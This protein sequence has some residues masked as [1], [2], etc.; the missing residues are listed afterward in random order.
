MPPIVL[1]DLSDDVLTLRPPVAADVPAITRIC[2]DPDIQRWTRVP[3]PYGPE[4]ART[5]VLM[6][7]GA[8]AE[9]RGAHLLATP[10]GGP[11]EEVWGCV[12]VSR[13]AADLTGELGYWVAPG[14]RGQRVATRA[15]RLMARFAFDHLGLFA[16]HLHT[17]TG[18]AASRRVAQAIGFRH[19]GV[20]RNAMPDGATGDPDAARTD[21]DLYDLLPA[22]LD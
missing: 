16:L 12:G 8:L 20:L 19:V 2:R 4:D 10:T 7:T 13:D 21:V 6:A 11:L 1:P 18:N 17:A 5:F 9:G 3:S 15:A 14:A 22:D